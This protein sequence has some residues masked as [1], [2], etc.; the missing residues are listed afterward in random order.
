[1]L[2]TACQGPD[3]TVTPAEQGSMAQGPADLT[4][5]VAS[6]PA[7]FSQETAETLT[8]QYFGGLNREARYQRYKGLFI[9]IDTTNLT[10]A[11]SSARFR[12]R[13]EGRVWANPN[14]DT[15][16]LPYIDTLVFD[17]RWD[18]SGWVARINEQ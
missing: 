4:S 13:V 15:S 14:R 2:I 3:R 12:A 5:A 9:V 6:S 7:P 11:D 1:M 16:T 10:V 18:G 17:A 8:A